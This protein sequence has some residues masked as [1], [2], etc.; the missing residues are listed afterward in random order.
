M[1][2]HIRCMPQQRD[3]GTIPDMV[4]KLRIAK[5]A[6]ACKHKGGRGNIRHTYALSPDHASGGM[7]RL[8]AVA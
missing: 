7:N 8:A 2:E 1:L 6:V 4:N 3:A 5:R